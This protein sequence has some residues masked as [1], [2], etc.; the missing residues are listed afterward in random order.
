MEALLLDVRYAAG[1]GAGL[2][3]GMQSYFVKR[4]KGVV[5]GTG[6]FFSPPP[7]SEWAS[8]YVVVF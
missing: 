4:G 8:F 5:M 1:A 7:L 3:R 6:L 2:W